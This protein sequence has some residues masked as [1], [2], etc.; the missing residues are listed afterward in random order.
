VLPN[1]I[2]FWS[3]NGESSLS[4]SDR[5]KPVDIAINESDSLSRVREELLSGGYPVLVTR[6]DSVRD[7]VFDLLKYVARENLATKVIINARAGAVED[8]VRKPPRRPTTQSRFLWAKARRFV[9][10]DLPST[11]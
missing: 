10:Y 7:P 8:A 6:C 2:L 9:K 5:L 1:S 4:L 11:S 3:L